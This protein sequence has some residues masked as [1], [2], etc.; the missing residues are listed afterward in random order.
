[1]SSITAG[2]AAARDRAYRGTSW[3][4]ALGI[5]GRRAFRA[6]FAGYM[7]DALE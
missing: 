3:W 5:E 7:L 2:R 4:T 6:A 1:M